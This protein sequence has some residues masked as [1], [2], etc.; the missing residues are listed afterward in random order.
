MRTDSLRRLMETMTFAQFRELS[1]EY[2][3]YRGYGEAVITDGWSDGG[4]DLRVYQI[5]SPAPRRIAI[6]VSVQE[7]G[8]QTKL[9][10]DARKALANLGCGIFLYVTN[11]RL[12]DAEYQPVEDELL[13]QDGISCSKADADNMA[14][15]VLDD[16]R[17]PW[18]LDL[19]AIKLEPRRL[20]IS[21]RQEV[22]DAFT[23]FSDEAEDY[24]RLFVE[25]ALMVSADRE[26]NVSREQILN[27]ARDAL[28]LQTG[29]LASQLSGTFDRLLQSQV[30]FRGEDGKFHLGEEMSRRLRQAYQL[31]DTQWT[32]L[33]SDIRRI[34]RK[35]CPSAVSN[36]NISESAK[37][38]A[39]RLGQVLRAYRDYQEHI[40]TRS[41]PDGN[42]RRQCI[43]EASEVEA[44]L[45]G[46]GVPQ[47]QLSACLDDI[48]ELQK[49]NPIVPLLEA[50]E[51]FRRLVAGNSQNLLNALGQI[52]GAVVILDTSV[53]IP[54]IC[55]QLHGEIKEPD[56]A[57]AM[58]LI[59]DATHHACPIYAPSVYLEEAAA[60]LIMAGRFEPV[61]LSL[62][63]TE[64]R[65]SEN[66]FVSYFARSNIPPHGFRNFL[67]S[68]GFR[69]ARGDFNRQL[70][71]VMT[72]L[73]GLLRRYNVARQDIDQRHVDRNAT[74]EAETELGN[75]YH[76]LNE[77]RPEILFA[78]DALVLAQMRAS[79][80]RENK[81]QLLATWD[82]CMQRAC[83]GIHELVLGLDPLNIAEL[84]ELAADKGEHAP[85]ISLIVQLGDREVTLSSRIW[86]VIVEVEKED[87]SDAA[88][89]AKAKRF[90]DAFL[91]RQQADTMRTHQIVTAWRQWK[92]MA[93]AHEN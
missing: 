25:W 63:R 23:L 18:L 27:S 80:D 7:R 82:R 5:G 4:S 22:T 70:G 3:R 40:I 77:D 57:G 92:E 84:F 38:L 66:A 83:H 54:L 36:D 8:W 75:I 32:E 72:E 9:K 68:F 87:L 61:V 88:L 67:E 90:K 93:D 60:H 16:D 58:H 59:K 10:E 15:Y 6:Q 76:Q 64:L 50:G 17:V 13:R 85:D 79:G 73:S 74:R 24:R 29:A 14:Q 41:A 56:V 12:A 86:D 78:H 62:P 2:I 33:V 11:R 31:R 55:G 45:R 1:R 48:S 19:M 28:G 46:A 37:Q 44:M 34:L 71:L 52:S 53:L 47:S 39:T 35:Y 20:D 51:T 81:S 89:L 21:I 42:A 43:R 26:G 69:G 30:I 65:S 91:A 49:T